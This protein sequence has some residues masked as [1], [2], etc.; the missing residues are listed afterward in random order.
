MS[1]FQVG[2]MSE[3]IR[4]EERGIFWDLM[5]MISFFI[6]EEPLVSSFF[7]EIQ[8]STFLGEL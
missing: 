8:G 4:W 2:T 6:R 5:W 1:Q 7:L 3:I